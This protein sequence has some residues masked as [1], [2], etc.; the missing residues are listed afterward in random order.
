MGAVRGVAL[1]AEGVADGD[2]EAHRR[3]LH[4]D[5]G[6]GGATRLVRVAPTARRSIPYRSAIGTLD[7]EHEGYV[8]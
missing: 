8:G 7:M 1:P 3:R 2:L 5:R 4:R 6:G